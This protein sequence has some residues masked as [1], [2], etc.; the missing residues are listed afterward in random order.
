ML[1]Q[2]QQSSQEH[3]LLKLDISKAFDNMVWPY[4][5][6]TMEK[7]GMN[8]MLS[9]FLK[10]S[11]SSTTSNI[12]L[13]G[14]PTAPFKLACSVRQ[15]CPLSPLV[16]I[17]AFDNFS[18]MIN[19]AKIR[20]TL[21][22][23]E[24]PDLGMTNI[25]S[26]YV[27]DASVMIRAEMRYV[28]VLKEILEIFGAATGLRFIWEKTRSAFIRGGPMAFWM[29]P[30]SWEEDSNATN[31]LGFPTASSFLTSQMETIVS[32]KIVRGI[33][34]LQKRQLSLAGCILAANNLI[35]STIWFLSTL[36][37]GELTFF[38][39]MQRLIEEFVWGGRSRVNHHT[40]L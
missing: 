16:F 15:G 30:W 32:D 7:A 17:L 26:M 18:L 5:L 11:F 40:S 33:E 14:R 36:W 27:D 29:L 10:A 25:L 2:A 22:G 31:M 24:F 12:I 34:K 21:V 19:Q 37:A 4:I 13:N 39:K 6:A 20:R 3:I 1:H 8:G 38:S 35:L 23:V 28:M 9:G